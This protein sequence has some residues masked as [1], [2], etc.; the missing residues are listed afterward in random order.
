M[1]TKISRRRRAEL[2]R[3]AHQIRARGQRAGWPVARIAA[4]IQTELP[5]VLPL[6][7]W[8]WAY[9]WS[10]AQTVRMV[11]GYY[12]THQLGTARLNESMLC[13]WEHGDTRPGPDYAA[14]L[15]GVYGTDP[16]QLGLWPTWRAAPHQPGRHG[17][18]GTIPAPKDG[19]GYPMH[20]LAALRESVEL[21]MEVEGPAGGPQTIEAVQAAV[22]Y[23]DLHYSKW[24]PNVLA[25]EVHRTRALVGNMLR[26][27]PPTEQRTDLRRLAGWLSAIAGNLAFHLADTDAAAV[28]LATAER[29]GAA[30][31][32]TWLQCWALGA[33]SMV[34]HHHDR[35]AEAIEQRV[36]RGADQAAILRRADQMLDQRM[37]TMRR[38]W[39]VSSPAA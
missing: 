21:T 19:Y 23:Y 38:R 15:C 18:W 33:R 12:Q 32:D 37:D 4:V 13:R 35:H 39:H 11:A 3:A 26:H 2:A 36:R 6:E 31:G 20:S 25:A 5:E 1:T 7:A 9:G 28:H 14:A 22:T 8:R 27:D 34:A 16:A 24:A 10:R 17:A 29:L 30:A